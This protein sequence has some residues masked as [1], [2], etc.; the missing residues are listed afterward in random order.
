MVVEVAPSAVGFRL[1]FPGKEPTPLATFTRDGVVWIVLERR[2]MLDVSQVQAREREIGPSD[3]SAIET[4]VAATILRLAPPMR[5]SVGVLRDGDTWI[6]EIGPRPAVPLRPVEPTIRGNSDGSNGRVVVDMPGV[7]N[8][9]RLRDAEANDELLVAPTLSHGVAVAVTRPFPEFRVMP[10]GQGLVVLPQSDRVHVKLVGEVVEITGM[11]PL[12]VPGTVQADAAAATSR[13]KL[14]D[15]EAWRGRRETFDERKQALHR[16]VAT[17][18][19]QKR[20]A[21]RLALA[22][23]LFANGLAV[24]ALGQLRTLET[25]APRLAATPAVRTLRGAAAVL[26][27]DIDD[28]DR[29]LAQPS[30]AISNEA[31]L[32]RG[33]VRLRQEDFDAASELTLRGLEFAERY[34]PPIGPKVALAIAQAQVAAGTNDDAARFLDLAQRQPLLDSDQRQLALLRGR[35]LARQGDVPGALAAWKPL[36]EGGPSPTRAEAILARVETAI[37]ARQMDKGQAI[38]TLDRLRFTWRGDRT[39]LRTLL[40]LARIHGENGN[41]RAGLLVLREAAVQFPAARKGREIATE[42]DLLFARLFLEGEADKLPP[43][44]A[45]ALFEEFRDLVPTGTRGDAMARRLADRL[46]EVDLMER[47]AALLEHQVKHRST[48]AQRAELG[49]RLATVRLL[50][51][52][53]EAALQALAASDDAAAPDALKAERRRL[54]SRALA[55]VGRNAEALARLGDDRSPDADRLR[56]EIMRQARDWRGVA[57]TLR[58]SVGEPPPAGAKL[59][60][61]K[62]LAVLHEATALALAGDEAALQQLRQQFGAAMEASPFDAMFKVVAA[63]QGERAVDVAAIAQQVAAAAPYQSFLQAY[64]DKLGTPADKGS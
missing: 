38:D 20:G 46:V 25:E 42:M 16:A 12:V 2:L 22:Q 61:D 13:Q 1:R 64:R 31:A 23:L 35:I 62:A 50:D 51:A 45:I 44:Q 7:R 47:A 17:A 54:E 60:D 15:P 5:A 18:T 49:A 48:G 24:E 3:V 26:A 37:A 43:V 39:E 55:D 40:A 56:V 33:I 28:A 63:E 32:W 41:H 30:L 10:S 53:P 58:R 59:A 11:T 4:P 34:P 21:E 57:E 9:L 27:D 29:S 6:V 14:L 36:E 8:V 19:P 52:K